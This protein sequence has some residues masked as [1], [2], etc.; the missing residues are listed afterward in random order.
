MI[1]EV[2]GKHSSLP[3][4]SSQPVLHAYILTSEYTSL[5]TSTTY[6]YVIAFSTGLN[7]LQVDQVN[8]GSDSQTST[9][10]QFTVSC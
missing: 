3:E 5:Q 6:T 7:C 1:V 9:Y 2:L 4:T 8:R 10:T